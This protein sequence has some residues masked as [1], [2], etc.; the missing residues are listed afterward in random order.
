MGKKLWKFISD[1]FTFKSLLSLPFW[2][3]LIAIV[4]P[5]ILGL[6]A[7][8]TGAPWYTSLIL[9]FTVL[10]GI[11]LLVDQGFRCWE[12][13]SKKRSKF[14]VTLEI[15]MWCPDSSGRLLFGVANGDRLDASRVAMCFRI[16]TTQEK[17]LL[18]TFKV[19][20]QA[21]NGNWLRLSMLEGDGGVVWVNQDVTEGFFV[22]PS[23][24]WLNLD[25][26]WLKAQVPLRGWVFYTYG[27]LEDYTEFTTKF[28]ITIRDVLGNEEKKIISS[29][30][31]NQDSVLRKKFKIIEKIGL[32]KF[33]QPMQ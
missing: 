21:T 16:M 20:I 2:S 12:W 33:A 10:I 24:G 9:V 27:D 3:G 11:S 1:L 25:E 4:T 32:S 8:I 22:E 13:V 17:V 28:R 18:E 7:W 23:P 31:A 30:P 14:S 26:W 15:L 5:F 19:E 6:I 29:P